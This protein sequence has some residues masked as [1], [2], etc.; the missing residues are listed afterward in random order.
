M[1]FS[2]CSKRSSDGRPVFFGAWLAAARD[3][4]VFLGSGLSGSNRGGSLAWAAAP[5][6]APKARFA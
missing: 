1:P 4:G 5:Q 3:F 6:V 2:T